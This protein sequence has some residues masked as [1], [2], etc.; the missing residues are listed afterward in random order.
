MK[1]K[2]N[3]SGYDSIW[4]EKKHK[5]I[6]LT[7]AFS[8]TGT[9]ADRGLGIILRAPDEINHYFIRT[10]PASLLIYKRVAGA[11]VALAR[12]GVHVIDGQTYTLSASA[13]GN[14]ISAD[15]NGTHIEIEDTTF[16]DGTLVAVASWGGDTEVSGWIDIPT[17]WLPWI[18]GG[19]GIAAI[20]AIIAKKR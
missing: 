18:A 3:L 9:A 13:Q 17:D 12:V 10:F 15:L 1:R 7:S 8:I 5:D 20:V 6:K 14:L 19:I 11:P 4:Y 2:F 16:K